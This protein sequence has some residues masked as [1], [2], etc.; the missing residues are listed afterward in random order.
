MGAFKL[1]DPLFPNC[2]FPV[3]LVARPHGAGECRTALHAAV[4]DVLQIAGFGAVT[5]PH[6][7]NSRNCHSMSAMWAGEEKA[8]QVRW[9]NAIESH[10]RTTPDAQSTFR[11]FPN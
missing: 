7:R 9:N 2:G 10:R 1:T 11:Q 6:R 3:I 5:R 8:R 4:C